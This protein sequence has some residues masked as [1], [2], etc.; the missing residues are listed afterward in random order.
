MFDTVMGMIALQFL[1]AILFT[2]MTGDILG[3]FLVGFV[4]LPYL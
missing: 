4:C 1:S 3:W 2:A